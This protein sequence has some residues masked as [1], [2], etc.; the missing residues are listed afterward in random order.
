MQ[1]SN[2]EQTPEGGGGGKLSCI[3]PSLW[4]LKHEH[5]IMNLCKFV[6]VYLLL[7]WRTW[8]RLRKDQHWSKRRYGTKSS[9]VSHAESQWSPYTDS[10]MSFSYWLW[11][12]N[13][14]WLSLF[15]LTSD[16]MF[17]IFCTNLKSENWPERV[18]PATFQF[19]HTE[20]KLWRLFFFSGLANPNR[21]G[22]QSVRTEK[23]IRRIGL[24]TTLRKENENATSKKN[25]NFE[26]L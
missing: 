6:C 5:S 10:S 17:S 13:C 18:N 26:Y 9:E 3:F 14:R 16:L 1:S 2:T 15:C 23:L 4:L 12:N 19:S 21:L 25:N 20:S 11:N 24:G 7:L 22:D 8:L